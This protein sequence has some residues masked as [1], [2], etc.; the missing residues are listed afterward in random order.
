MVGGI[1]AAAVTVSPS[2][3]MIII[4]ALSVLSISLMFMIGS[5]SDVDD[6]LSLTNLTPSTSNEVY[7][8]LQSNNVSINKKRRQKERRDK[9]RRERRRKAQEVNVDDE[10]KDKD[11]V[12]KEV[13]CDDEDRKPIM[14]TYFDDI[15][16]NVAM[17]DEENH[18]L[19]NV[20]TRSWNDAGFDT[21]VLTKKD[22]MKH[23]DF[24][25]LSKKL[26]ELGVDE[27]NQVC[28]WRWLAMAMLKDDCQDGGWMSDYDTFPLG[29][30][31]EEALDIEKMPGFK[32][33]DLH[34]PNIIHS[35]AEVSIYVIKGFSLLCHYFHPDVV[36]T[37]QLTLYTSLFESIGI[38]SYKN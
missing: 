22:A 33:Y 7:R 35:D 4:V 34:V 29:L 3:R 12:D 27:Y 19:I 30:T 6:S 26:L 10:D 25:K 28:F 21:V 38:V 14:H 8:Q 20:W 18:Q 23:P 13:D 17:S 31:A 9:R 1:V 37:K 11:D 36:C 2:Q 16:Q 5:G 24:E 15:K 32:S